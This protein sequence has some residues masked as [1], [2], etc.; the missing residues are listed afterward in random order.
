MKPA[1][2]LFLLLVVLAACTSNEER[3]REEPLSTAETFRWTDQPLTFQPPPADWRRDRYNEGGL[4]GVHFTHSRSVGERI[5]IAEYYTIGE[6]SAREG[7]RRRYRLEDVVEQTQFSTEG[8]PLPPD[9]F[10]VGDLLPD[11]VAGLP[12]FRLDFTLNTPER[13]LVG[14]EY[15]FLKSN[16]L[17]EAAYLGLPV[18]LALFERVVETISFPEGGKRR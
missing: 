11:T 13:T 7:H 12:A 1:R 15:Y 8:W 5:Y 4:L 17:F 16:Y 18:N 9:S 3:A 2:L 10:I 14:R 6:R